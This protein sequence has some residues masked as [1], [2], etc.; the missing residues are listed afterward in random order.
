[1]KVK[2]VVEVF[3]DLNQL[4]LEK[5][6]IQLIYTQEN[7]LRDEG[8]EGQVSPKGNQAR[9]RVVYQPPVDCQGGA[10]SDQGAKT[11]NEAC[12]FG[13]VVGT[14]AGRYVVCDERD[15]LFGTRSS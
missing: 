7:I 1:M 3:S 9:R 8:G 14:T 15:A 11:V 5:Y 12:A 10:L 4:F 13:H 2:S 6:I